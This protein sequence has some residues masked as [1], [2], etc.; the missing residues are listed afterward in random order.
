MGIRALV[1]HLAGVVDRGGRTLLQP[2]RQRP[3]VDLRSVLPHDRPEGAVAADRA[4]DLSVVVEVDGGWRGVVIGPSQEGSCW[5]RPQAPP[6]PTSRCVCVGGSSALISSPGPH[7][8]PVGS[9]WPV[10]AWL[11][12]R[13]C[14]RHAGGEPR[15]STRAGCVLLLAGAPQERLQRPGVEDV[16][17]RGP[18]AARGRER[19]RDVVE[20][21]RGV[22]VG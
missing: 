5:W 21:R 3:Q 2:T 11:Y 22:R 6:R 15:R 18:P 19:Q 16:G 20:A 10:T 9:K 17:G 13:D 14:R 8:R 7:V 1:H 4:D 12:L